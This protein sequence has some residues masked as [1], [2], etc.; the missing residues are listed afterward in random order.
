MLNFI[1]YQTSKKEID[2]NVGLQ[3]FENCLIN[4]NQLSW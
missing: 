3:S 2:L 4:L 1:C